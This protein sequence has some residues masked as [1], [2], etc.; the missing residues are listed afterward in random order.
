M[1]LIKK[2]TFALCLILLLVIGVVFT[3]R[4][5]QPVTVD[6]LLLQTPAWSLGLWLLLSVFLGAALGVLASSF[7][8]FRLRL[9]NQRLAKE[10]KRQT[11][12]L[13]TFMREKQ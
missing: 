11:Q 10:K 13:E 5:D 4:N 7:S 1:A 2:I 12:E 8:L 3:L 6:F 9:R